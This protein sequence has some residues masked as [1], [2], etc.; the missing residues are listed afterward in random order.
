MQM[1]IDVAGFTPGEADQLRQAMGSKRSRE[2]MER[3]RASGSTTAWPS[4]ASPA[5]SPT[6]IYDKLAA[7]ANFGFPES[8]SVSFAYLVYA[9][10]VD[11][12]PLPGGVLR[13]AAQRPAHGLLLAALAGAGRP[14]PRRRGA[15]PRPQRARPP[16]PPSSGSR[17]SPSP[18]APKA[19]RPARPPTAR[20]RRRRRARASHRG[21]W[22]Y[23]GRRGRRRAAGGAAGAVVGALGRRRPGR[24][25]RGRPR[26]ADGPYASMEDL[27]R[28]VDGID[29][30]ILEA[31]ATAG[32]F[33]CFDRRRTAVALDRRRALWAAGAV[34]QSGADRLAGVVTGA[35]APQLPGHGRP[36]GRR[37]R[38]VGHRRRPRRPPHPVR[39]RRPRPR[40]AW[41]PPAGLRDGRPGRP[42]AG[43]R[44]GHPPPAPGHRRGHH[45]HQPRG[46]DRPHQRDLLEGAAGPATA[47]WPAARAGPAGAGSPRAGRGRHQRDRRQARAPAAR[48]P[49]SRSRDFR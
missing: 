32:A 41:S 5:R 15:H 8:H 24:A 20:R 49:R 21:R 44:R 11:Q 29:R 10:V 45:L 48:R 1:A 25:H 38:P 35:E 18:S 12:A 2:R 33:G 46:R 4:G 37:G 39:A 19:R 28:R 47:R 22:R 40:W 27:A 30:G 34:A 31:L 7:F 42:G 36:R 6:S 9:S 17:A 43:G 23:P 26:E 13:G 16:A 3:L 14:P